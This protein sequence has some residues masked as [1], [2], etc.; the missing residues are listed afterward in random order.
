MGLAR[1]SRVITLDAPRTGRVEARLT[2]GARGALRVSFFALSP[3]A[4]GGNSLDLLGGSGENWSVM[5]TLVL[6]FAARS[7]ST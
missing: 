4:G 2:C 1:A 6:C 7:R 3:V 5:F